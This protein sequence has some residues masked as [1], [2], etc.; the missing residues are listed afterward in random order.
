MEKIGENKICG[1]VVWCHEQDTSHIP[2]NSSGHGFI[3]PEISQFVFAYFF[4]I[5]TY[6]NGY[7][8][9]EQ[10]KERTLFFLIGLNIGISNCWNY[11]YLEQLT[12]AE[13]F[14]NVKNGSSFI[15]SKSLSKNHENKHWCFCC[16]YDK[17]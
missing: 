4:N 1:L 12:L 15:M 17:P 13:V 9:S 5:W 3:N 2:L 11:K 10:K 7:S 16:L 8:K 14:Y 6:Q